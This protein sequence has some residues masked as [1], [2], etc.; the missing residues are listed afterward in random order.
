MTTQSAPLLLTY[1]PAIE[2]T[3]DINDLLIAARWRISKIWNWTQGCSARDY[4]GRAVSLF[5][6]NASCFCATGIVDSVAMYTH[7]SYSVD[8]ALRILRS[9]IPAREYCTV[10][11]YNDEHSHAEVLA[12]F[13]RAIHPRE[14]PETHVTA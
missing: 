10:P 2:A 3:S 4:K 1:H 7:L 9:A 11:T 5:D 6:A 8:P 13:D 14:T 12:L